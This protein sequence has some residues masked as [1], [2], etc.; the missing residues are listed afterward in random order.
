MT[1]SIILII[2]PGP[3]PN[4]PTLIMTR[5]RKSKTSIQA[6][7]CSLVHDDPR[8]SPSARKM[9]RYSNSTIEVSNRTTLH[10]VG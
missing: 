3:P 10:H 5:E 6:S 7:S 4:S 8:C 2:P 9:A 1:S